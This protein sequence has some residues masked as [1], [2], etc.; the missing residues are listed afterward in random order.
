MKFIIS[1]ALLLLLTGCATSSGVRNAPIDA[2][3]SKHFDAPYAEV[4]DAALY[5]TQI[6]GV[7][8]KGAY[9]SEQAYQIDF[10]KGMSL[11]SNG[12]IGRVMVFDSD[13]GSLVRVYSE[14]RSKYQITG[15]DN[16][17][18]AFSIFMGIEQALIDD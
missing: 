9:E 6:L 3:H 1:L 13:P 16:E 17:E 15:T 14:K 8:I 5:S 10:E 12:E 2:G 18:F 4:K 7:Q 11:A